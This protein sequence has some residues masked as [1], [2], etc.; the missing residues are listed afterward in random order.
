MDCLGLHQ[1]MASS[2]IA[3]D[4]PDD[5]WID[6]SATDFTSKHHL[7]PTII[8]LNNTKIQ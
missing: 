3:V 5:N 1:S 7:I 2:H 6:N 4:V 8:I